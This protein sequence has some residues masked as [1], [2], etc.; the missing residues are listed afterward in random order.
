MKKII[1]MIIALA[2]VLSLGVTAFA[3]NTYTITIGNGV[4]G[5]TYYAYK[6]LDVTLAETNS[7]HEGYDAY[8]YSITTD[9]PFFNTVTGRAST[10]TTYADTY[11]KWGLTFKKSANFANDNTYILIAPLTDT[12]DVDAVGLAAAIGAY[13]K[14]ND[15]NHTDADGSV[16]YSSNTKTIS[17]TELG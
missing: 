7:Q 8:A 11:T 1:T 6:V 2:L 13:V 14:A 10:A 16:T 15:P 9:S 3:A 4:D 5:E 12:D 17:V